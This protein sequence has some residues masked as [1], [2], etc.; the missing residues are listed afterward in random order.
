MSKC[1]KNINK[2]YICSSAIASAKDV[3]YAVIFCRSEVFPAITKHY[4]H[5]VANIKIFYLEAVVHQ[6]NIKKTP[7]KP[8]KYSE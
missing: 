4:L 8:D 6:I 5:I 1:H 3:H 2:L 7:N